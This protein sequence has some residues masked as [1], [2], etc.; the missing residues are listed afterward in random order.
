MGALLSAMRGR[1]E[2]APR[3]TRED[4][5]PRLVAHQQGA[6]HARQRAPDVDDAHAVG[7]VVDDPHLGVA[8]RDGDRLEAD[9]HARPRRQQAAGPDREDLERAGGGVRDVELRAVRRERDRPDRSALEE[10]IGRLSG[11]RDGRD[12]TAEDHRDVQRQQDPLSHGA[13]SPAFNPRAGNRLREG[14]S[15]GRN[16]PIQLF[17]SGSTRVANRRMLCSASSTGMPP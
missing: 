8:R 12:H 5:V 13:T 4:D 15:W 17:S 2:G 7:E 1:D 11:R 6:L 16:A 14:G 10:E 9:G 3:K